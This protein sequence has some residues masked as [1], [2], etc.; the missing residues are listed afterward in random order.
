MK[1]THLTDVRRGGFT[2]IELLVVIAVIALLAGMI[3]PITGAVNRAKIRTKTKAELAQVEIAI[4]NYKTKLG[5]Y[6]PDSGDFNFH[7]LYYELVGT[8]LQ[9]N[10]FT[11]LDNSS[12]VTVPTLTA[13]F[14]GRVAGFINS[15]R[16]G[17]EGEGV[18][19]TSFLRDLKPGQVATLANHN[20]FRVLTCSV[21]W[22]ADRAPIIPN[23]PG[24]NPWR[25]N[26]SSPTN[27]PNSFDLWADVVINNKVFRISNWSREPIQIT[28]P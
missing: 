13:L 12:A 5:H 7:Q 17:A 14:G 16:P 28:T 8:A 6:P 18:K 11:T 23:Q 22:P 27:N 4:M 2:L 21:I 19:A 1:T 24:V 3:F 15:S 10:I 26:S 9:N 25:Y 20:D